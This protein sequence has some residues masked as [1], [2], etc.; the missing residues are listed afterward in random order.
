MKQAILGLLFGAAIDIPPWF[1]ESV[2]GLGGCAA[3]VFGRFSKADVSESKLNGVL[4]TVTTM[5]DA[6]TK[7]GQASAARQEQ[8][9]NL[10]TTD[11]NQWTSINA[12]RAELST[13]RSEVAYLRGQVGK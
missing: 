11:G 4:A 6:V 10:Q 7:M 8:I 2:T 1:I 12:L 5:G 13:L 3:Y 9:A